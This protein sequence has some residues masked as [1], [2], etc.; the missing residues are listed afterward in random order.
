MFIIFGEELLEGVEIPSCDG[1]EKLRHGGIEL[2]G[3]RFG[4]GHRFGEEGCLKA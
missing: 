1:L 4:D 3:R 2:R